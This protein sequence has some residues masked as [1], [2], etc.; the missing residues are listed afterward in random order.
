MSDAGWSIFIQAHI[1][2]ML[3]DDPNFK[4]FEWA[5]G[6]DAHLFR[7]WYDKGNAGP[8]RERMT[9]AASADEFRLSVR[10]CYE[11]Y[12]AFKTSLPPEERARIVAKQEQDLTSKTV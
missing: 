7:E 4:P 12:L 8:Y 11:A 6:E 10:D 1:F 3:S 9:N 5:G 2:A